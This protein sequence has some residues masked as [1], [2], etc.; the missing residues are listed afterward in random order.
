MEADEELGPHG[1]V[2]LEMDDGD[3]P[4]D[5]LNGSDD[6][7][8]SSSASI[9]S[10]S[11][12]TTG[13]D[14]YGT[15]WPQTYRQSIDM[16]CSV[17]PIDASLLASSN[18][19]HLNGSFRSS[20][21]HKRDQHPEIIH[22]SLTEPFLPAIFDTERTST[23]RLPRHSSRHSS[24]RLSTFDSTPLRQCSSF[25]ATFNGINVLCGVGLLS[26]PY[27]ISNGGWLSLLVLIM[28]CLISCYTGFLLKRCLDHTPGLSTY[29]DIAEAA[30]GK[31]GR[32]AISVTLYIELYA[33]C[34]QFITLVSDNL[35]YLYPH[36]QLSVGGI[37]LG[38]HL[39]FAIAAAIVIL[40]TICIRNLSLLSYLSAGGVVV[41]VLV[42]ICLLW[43]GAVDGV[44]F[45]PGG[46]ALEIANFPVAIGIYGFC[47]S[48]HTLFPN[49][50]SSMK[51]PEQFPVVLIVSFF[52][53]LILY[54]GVA[55]TGFLMFGSLV[56]SQ[57][58]LNL[59]HQ[60]MASK[61]AVW[62]TVINPFS[63]YALMMTPVALGIEELMPR[64][65]GRSH[66]MLLLIPRMTLVIS[67]LVV[68][69]TVP[70]FGFV[71]AFLGS[72]F[73]MLVTF[74]FPCACYLSIMRGSI[75]LPQVVTC[76]VIM[77]VGF[78]CACVGS[79]TAIMKIADKV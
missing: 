12:V 9:S 25:Q 23:H 31:I 75:S 27:A 4:G 26:T 55:V 60:F 17:T 32:L 38:T 61:I 64:R 22:S 7:E 56:N 77:M 1:D 21:P 78:V 46:T 51:K 39:V 57:F 2:G 18:L 37:N 58:T 44:G 6:D 59:P 54:A 3:F 20:P 72:F 24:R 11:S 45:H 67:T 29:P 19:N 47:F 66:F 14:F 65:Q 8:I 62:T 68:A 28:F 53:C 10:S 35:S 76:S 40:P 33:C 41:S 73:T 16:L 52:T 48:G 15:S 42:A 13:G 74:I 49:I 34:V 79:Y 50:Y 30:F 43:V 63:K 71:M 36:T 69:L 5:G 70:F